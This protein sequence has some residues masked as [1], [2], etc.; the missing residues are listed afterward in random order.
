[1]RWSLVITLL[2]ATAAAADRTGAIAGRVVDTHTGAPVSRATVMVYPASGAP[3]TRVTGDD[4]TFVCGTLPP[5]DY[6]V[7]AFFGDATARKDHVVV[8]PDRDTQV[9]LPV[10][11][12]A[13][14]EVVTIKER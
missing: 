8:E 10:D 13:G 7:F 5:G 11:T 9:S 12:M 6:S 3:T 14:A 4:G 2:T 1:M